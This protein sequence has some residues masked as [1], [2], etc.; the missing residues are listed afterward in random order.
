MLPIKGYE[1]VYSIDEK[2]NVFSHRKNRFINTYWQISSSGKKY[3]RV[4]L[5]KNG[6]QK[7]Y[8]VHRLIAEHYIPNDANYKIIDH[9]DRNPENNN[10]SNLRWCSYSQNRVNR[11]KV[12]NKTSKYIGVSFDKKAKKKQW[13][14]YIELNNKAY[15]LGRF[16]TEK[17]AATAYNEKARELH[18]EFANIN[19]IE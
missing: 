8:G 6:T 7:N 19:V 15:N 11:S 12:K 9:I 5:C 18:K 17:E 4:S 1:N 3:K 16:L 2:G 10:I 13:V 14:A